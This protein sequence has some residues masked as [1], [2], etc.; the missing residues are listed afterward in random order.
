[1]RQHFS[2]GAGLDNPAE[3]DVT[4]KSWTPTKRR[5]VR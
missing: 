3:G 2:R 4:P 1:M 5:R